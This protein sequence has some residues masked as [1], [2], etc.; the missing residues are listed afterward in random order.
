MLLNLKVYIFAF[1][2]SLSSL[3]FK[4]ITFSS[5][6]F[7]IVASPFIILIDIRDGRNDFICYIL[8]I[9]HQYCLNKSDK[10]WY[11]NV[12]TYTIVYVYNFIVLYL[13]SV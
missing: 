4:V 10:F 1:A 3:L 9:E 8:R 6:Q 5:T 13:G 2:Q 12:I 11:T 7:S